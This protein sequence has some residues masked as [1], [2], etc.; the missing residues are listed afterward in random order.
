MDYQYSLNPNSVSHSIF[1]L[2]SKLCISI[3][4]GITQQLVGTIYTLLKVIK[5]ISQR[6]FLEKLFRQGLLT[7]HA[8]FVTNRIME[9]FKS[10]STHSELNFA[11]T[12]RSVM[13]LS[14]MDAAQDLENTKR[15][16]RTL[17]VDSMEKIKEITSPQVFNKFKAEFFNIF[18]RMKK[19]LWHKLK[20]KNIKS[21][22]FKLK[23]KRGEMITTPGGSGIQDSAIIES[24]VGHMQSI[25]RH[26]D[27]LPEDHPHVSLYRR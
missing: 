24:Q 4:H 5:K 14:V 7:S 1:S 16:A 19:E 21:I 2:L 11:M 12:A 18:S 6:D 17:T 8:V 15:E 20:R 3:H 13:S 23:K 10:N 26:Q 9:A 22:D 25:Q 27:A